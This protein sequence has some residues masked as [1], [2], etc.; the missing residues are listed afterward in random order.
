MALSKPNISILDILV[1]S[2]DPPIKALYL[3][4]LCLKAG[5]SVDLCLHWLIRTINVLNVVVLGR[6]PLA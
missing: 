4:I 1:L 5:V 3:P 2:T 6:R